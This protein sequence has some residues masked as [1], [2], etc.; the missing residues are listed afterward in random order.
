MD[1]GTLLAIITGIMGLAGL[2]YTALSWRRNDDK[3]VVEQQSVVLHDM[4]TLNDELRKALE[5]CRTERAELS[6][7]ER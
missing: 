6:R 2:I 1:A 4:G 7:R 5:D 3:A